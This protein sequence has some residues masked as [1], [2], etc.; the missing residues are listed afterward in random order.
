MRIAGELGLVLVFAIVLG[1][2][3]QR[4]RL[5]AITGQLLAGVILGPTVMGHLAGALHATFYSSLFPGPTADPVLAVVR[6]D[7][8]Q[9]GLVVFIFLVGLEVDPS[10]VVRKIRVIMPSSLLG[11]AVPFIVG[12]AAVHVFPGIWHTSGL[13][14]PD[15]MPWIIGV[16]L[17]VSALPVIAAILTDLG[18]IRT[19]IGSMIL[20]AAVLDDV[21]GWV[22]FA[23]I[24]S[25][26]TGGGSVW[27]AAAI[28]VVAFAFALT[29]GRRIGN[30]VNDW[31][32]THPT[33]P[34]LVVGLA[35]AAT[36][37]LSGVMEGIGSHAFFGALL[38]GVMCSAIG[39]DRFEPVDQFARSYFAPLYF[40]ALGLSVDF[41]ANFDLGLV[42]VVLLIACLGKLAGVF[43]G[44]R[45][46]GTAPREAFAIA[47]GMNARGSVEILLATLALSYSLIDGH[48]FVA[49]VI[50]AIGTSILASSAIP[51]ILR[52]ARPA[53][54]VRSSLPV[55]QRLD[56]AGS[57]S[58]RFRLG[59]G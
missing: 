37:M 6:R 11:L 10:I 7:F 19:E 13:K 8:L 22:A 20:A 25:A 38:V 34:G 29:V 23:A 24:V 30:L 3:A 1:H 28:V 9:L 2:I 31:L 47:A 40:G 21:C 45:L 52:I 32:N 18:I 12:F 59:S 42:V 41:A 36:L 5:P 27:Q 53:S 15:A 46:G 44:A 56:P 17:S 50:M 55:L 33:S 14:Q 57:P 58:K 43:M 54:L 48:V 51:R 4:F 16:A 49:I 26:F 35:L 39:A